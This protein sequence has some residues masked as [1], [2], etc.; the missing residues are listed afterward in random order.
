MKS[1]FL[2]YLLLTSA[3]SATNQPW[4]RISRFLVALGLVQDLLLCAKHLFVA[5]SAVWR[6]AA[7]ATRRAR[8]ARF[9]PVQS[10]QSG[11]DARTLNCRPSADAK[12]AAR[13]SAG[14]APAVLGNSGRRL[15]RARYA[16]AAARHPAH[17]A[18][19]AGMSRL[20]Q[21]LGLLRDGEPRQQHRRGDQRF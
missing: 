19:L 15:V 10:L 16:V 1:R 17:R 18:P 4:L 3:K 21:L 14:G 2:R 5:A 7:V 8:P 11:G 9:R 20:R 12:P 13:A 6:Q